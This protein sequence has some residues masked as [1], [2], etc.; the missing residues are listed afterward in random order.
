M[1]N[2]KPETRGSQVN[3][4]RRRLI[5]CMA[6]TFAGPIPTA[7]SQTNDSVS[8]R[9][10]LDESALK[11]IPLK[12]RQQLNVSKDSSAY[13]QEMIAAAPPQN[14]IPI[15]LIAVGI[16]AIP[17]IWEAILEMIREV[18]YGGVIFDLQQ[19]PPEITNSRTVPSGIILIIRPDGSFERMDSQNFSKTTIQGFFNTVATKKP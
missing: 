13:A 17:M 11:V 3:C 10:R 14:A 9:I 19:R 8:V 12:E 16:L 7:F 1:Y 5:F 6:A 2:L 4:G 15:I 18:E